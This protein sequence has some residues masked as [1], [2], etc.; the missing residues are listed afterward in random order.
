[1]GN[2]YKTKSFLN[3]FIPWI[4]VN[5]NMRIAWDEGVKV[6]FVV[7]IWNIISTITDFLAFWGFWHFL[8]YQRLL[9]IIVDYRMLQR[10]STKN[11]AHTKLKPPPLLK[12]H[13]KAWMVI[14]GVAG[15][16][17]K[18]QKSIIWKINHLKLRLNWIIN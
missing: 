8:D 17:L 5:E 9:E 7:Y 6:G 10:L 13:P 12:S 18:Q 16:E 1:M 15:I 14:M 4:N 11:W 2:L 3:A